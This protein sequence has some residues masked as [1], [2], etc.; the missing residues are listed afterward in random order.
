MTCCK[1]HLTC[2]FFATRHTILSMRGSPIIPALITMP[3]EKK[4]RKKRGKSKRAGRKK[5]QPTVSMV[6]HLDIG[7]GT[8]MSGN[9]NSRAGTSTLTWQS[10]QSESSAAVG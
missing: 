6:G 4:K 1:I 5:P 10:E 9:A 7:G 8:R 3:P 2:G